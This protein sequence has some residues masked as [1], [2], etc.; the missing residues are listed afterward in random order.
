MC[1]LSWRFTGVF[2]VLFALFFMN[3]P[4]PCQAE[5]KPGS[6]VIRFGVF[7]STSPKTIV[8]TYGPL[9]ALLERKLG[10]KITLL[11]APDDKIFLEK[12]RNG[13]Y[14]LLL[15]SCTLYF[16]L[17]PAGYKV[18]AKGDSF[19]YGGAVVRQDSEIKT[20]EQLKGKRVAAIGD[21]S[22]A[23]YHF[24]LSQLAEKGLNPGEDVAFQFL[25]KTD[26]I[27][28]GVINRKFAAGLLRLDALDH[29]AFA[30]I[31]DQVR[32]IARS[33]E[34]PHHPFIV[35][36][37]MDTSTIAAIQEAL[38]ALSPDR[39][40]ELGILNNMQVKKIVVATDV[41][42]AGFYEQIK[43]TDYFRKP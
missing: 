15:S 40:E 39:P 3:V 16:K 5:E 8:E 17:R 7:P 28:Y 18:I 20:L 29:P 11:S 22:Y 25:G 27:L 6:D 30:G 2:W 42:Y 21:Y 35:K 33:P 34:I 31:R 19:F 37:S 32:V 1:A 4:R 38:T 14:D 12:A 41:D 9:A 43:D 13:D 23:G 10:R 26:T 36:N 24:I